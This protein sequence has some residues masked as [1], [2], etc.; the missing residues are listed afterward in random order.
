MHVINAVGHAGINGAL[1]VLRGLEN[2]LIMYAGAVSGQRFK[3]NGFED[4][5]ASFRQAFELKGLDGPHH[6]SMRSASVNARN[7]FSRGASNSRDMFTSRLFGSA[8]T[9]V[10]FFTAA[11][12]ILRI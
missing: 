12:I 5:V 3:S 4:N 1:A 10:T 11:F 7:T 6:L 2:I 8:V 9:W